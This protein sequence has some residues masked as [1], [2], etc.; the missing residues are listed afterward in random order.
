[1]T[2]LLFRHRS[3]L[4]LARFHRIVFAL[5]T[6]ACVSRLENLVRLDEFSAGVVGVHD[7]DRFLAFVFAQALGKWPHPKPVDRA[8]AQWG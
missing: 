4:R 8:T 1:L 3:A 2:G 6:S 7:L 5:Q